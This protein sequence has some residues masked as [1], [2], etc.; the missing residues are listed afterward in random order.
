MVFGETMSRAELSS[1]SAGNIQDDFSLTVGS[2]TTRHLDVRSDNFF[3]E[4]IDPF[5]SSFSWVVSK[6]D[7]FV[8]TETIRVPPSPSID[9]S[10]HRSLDLSKMSRAPF[11][12]PL[13]APSSPLVR[14]TA[15]PSDDFILPP[16]AISPAFSD[17]IF[18][19]TYAFNAKICSSPPCMSVFSSE[20]Y[21]EDTQCKHCRRFYREQDL[22]KTKDVGTT[23]IVC[24]V[25]VAYPTDEQKDELLLQ[26]DGNMLK[27]LA[28]IATAR[29][30]VDDF[31]WKVVVNNPEDEYELED[32]E[33]PCG[34]IDICRGRCG[35]YVGG[36]VFDRGY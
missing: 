32:G 29:A 19:Q 11:Q 9:S 17:E 12:S 10:S 2:G 7:L 25:A 16:S 30:C 36:W 6:M 31:Y 27:V 5:W 18:W 14:Q 24:L 3:R 33:L 35:N 13:P 20:L 22:Y 8:S 21:S 23:C 26:S 1:T 15:E 34:C 28:D 4:L